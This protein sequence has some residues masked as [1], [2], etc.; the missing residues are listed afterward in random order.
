MKDS[1]FRCSKIKGPGP[2]GSLCHT[3]AR[4]CKVERDSWHGDLKRNVNCG[5]SKSGKRE[6]DSGRWKV[7][8]GM[9]AL[10]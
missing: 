3:D 1:G 6:T 4:S 10:P 2:E 7:K 5:R 8:R 9:F